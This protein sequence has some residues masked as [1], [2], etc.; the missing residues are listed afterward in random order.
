MKW[1]DPIPGF[2]CI[3]MKRKAQE[4]IYAEIQGLSP[5]ARTEY[6]RRAGA[7]GPLAEWWSEIKSAQKPAKSQP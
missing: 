7:Q 4:K 5:E 2:S 6:F 1:P 3:E